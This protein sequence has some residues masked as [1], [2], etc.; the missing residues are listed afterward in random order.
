MKRMPGMKRATNT[1]KGPRRLM[2][3]AIVDSRSGCPST[4]RA[5]RGSAFRPKR[6]PTQYP[7]L[8][9]ATALTTPTTSTTG[10]RMSPR[11]TR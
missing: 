7:R 11:Q 2:K 3:S 5:Y 4:Q 9:P 10:S 1:A 8:S 6:R